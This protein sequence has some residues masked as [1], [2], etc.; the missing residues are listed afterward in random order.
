VLLNFNDLGHRIQA[1]CQD[2]RVR[3]FLMQRLSV[4]MQ[5]GMLLAFYSMYYL[6]LWLT[7]L[8][9]FFHGNEQLGARRQ[10]HKSIWYRSGVYEFMQISFSGIADDDFQ[11]NFCIIRPL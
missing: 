10:D 4:A 9:Y 3:M 8:T 5:R 11:L 7:R 1:V 6:Y 2:T